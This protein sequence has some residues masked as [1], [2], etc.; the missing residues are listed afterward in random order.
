MHGVLSA[1]ND[2]A[3]LLEPDPEIEL[4][5]LVSRLRAGGEV[6][7]GGVGCARLKG[8]AHVAG[9]RACADCKKKKEEWQPLV[10]RQRQ[11]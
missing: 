10:Y 11:R 2:A 5:L 1:L 7:E 9:R 4:G 8:Y 3:P 6:L